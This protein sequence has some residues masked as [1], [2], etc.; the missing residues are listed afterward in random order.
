MAER[1][2]VPRLNMRHGTVLT[3]SAVGK[4][5]NEINIPNLD[6]KYFIFRPSMIEG[7]NELEF[8]GSVMP[9]MAENEI[10][11]AEQ[12]LLAIIG[13][14]Y[15]G[16]EIVRRSIEV[17]TGEDVT[18]SEDGIYQEDYGWGNI[19]DFRAGWKEVVKK[20]PPEKK[21]ETEEEKKAEE[22]DNSDEKKG[23]EEEEKYEDEVIHHEYKKVESTFSLDP[24]M[25]ES[26]T[27]FVSTCWQDS[28]NLHVMVPTQYPQLVKDTVSRATGYD[29]KKIIVHQVP[30][31]E[32]CNEYLLYPAII[33]A[34]AASSALALK[35]PVELKARSYNRRGRIKTKRTTYFSDDYKLLAEE[36]VHTIDMG[37]YLMLEREVERHAMSAIIPNYNLQ[38]FKASIKVEKSFSF[39]SFLFQS[40]GYS[41]A[42][43][44]TEYHSNIIAEILNMNPYE[45]RLYAYKEKRKFTDYLPAIAL[46]EEKKLLTDIAMKSSYSRKWSS[47]DLSKSDSKFLGYAKGIGI[48]SGIAI[49]GFSTSFSTE[50]EYQAKITYT[51]RGAIVV[52]TS[53]SEKTN[54]QPFWKKI[55]KEELS[56][57]SEDS[58]LFS[59]QDHNKI[60]TGPKILSRYITSFSKMLRN[61]ARKLKSLKESEKLPISISFNAEDKFFPCEFD[62]NG[63]AAMA[64]EVILPELSLIPKIKDVWVTYSVS[65]VANKEALLQSA[66]TLIARVLKENGMLIDR[67]SKI[68]IS[69]V[70]RQGENIASLTSLTRALVISSLASAL[71]QA[72]GKRVTLPLNAD[73]ILKIK[74]AKEDADK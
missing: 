57:D 44:S 70:K 43:A 11:Y 46:Q 20:N 31:Y 69:L 38:A 2:S 17:N 62:E 27:Y 16:A 72:I 60:D 5:I 48:S 33:S 19:E 26:N 52:E 49:A 40:M 24:I 54:A 68:N 1:T 65:E 7:V 23:H 25:Y 61:S 58:V 73:D 10:L 32:L 18:L 12:P 51:Q 59:S 41:E 29:K 34:I 13:P 67:D 30:Y 56:L 4:K 22:S 55:I 9:I 14:D 21:E 3:S 74:T 66:K 53:L 42:L 47:N 45:F 71:E 37:A 28:I 64:I 63:F 6:Q 15:E 35:A 50:N 39:P 36:V 8:A